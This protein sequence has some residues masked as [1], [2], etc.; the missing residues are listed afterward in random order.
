[1]DDILIPAPIQEIHDDRVR[2]ALARLQKAGVTLNENSPFSE[3]RI[4]FLGHVVCAEGREAD[5][6]MQRWR[7]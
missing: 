7:N 3:K 4:T 2:V 1:M 5:P 6:W